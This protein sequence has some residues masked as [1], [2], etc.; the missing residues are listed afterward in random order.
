MRRAIGQLFI[1]THP[2][3]KLNK[4]KKGDLKLLFWSVERTISLVLN[5]RGEQGTAFFLE[6]K[7]GWDATIRSGL[8]KAP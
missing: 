5:H 6:S 8:N 4:A 7:Q 3:P 1:Y 2:L